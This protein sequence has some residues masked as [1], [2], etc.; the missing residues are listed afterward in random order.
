[1]DGAFPL[2]HELPAVVYWIGFHNSC[3]SQVTSHDPCY[4]LMHL[5]SW[6][7]N[8]IMQSLKLTSCV[9]S[10]NQCVC[11][12]ILRVELVGHVTLAIVQ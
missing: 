7:L 3:N 5:A 10:S 12:F 6:I 11:L 8:L 4:F 9:T 1:M 2:V